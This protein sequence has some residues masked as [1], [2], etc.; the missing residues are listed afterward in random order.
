VILLAEYEGVV[1]MYVAAISENYQSIV[2]HALRIHPKYRGKNLGFLKIS[3]W[4]RNTY[5]QVSKELAITKT[6][7]L[8]NKTVR[9]ACYIHIMEQTFHT[10]R[11]IK[12]IHIP[13]R[14]SM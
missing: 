1:G 5:P 8:G 6:Q 9:K 3:K 13:C 4:C 2:T 12:K 7:R 10:V 14:S 11:L